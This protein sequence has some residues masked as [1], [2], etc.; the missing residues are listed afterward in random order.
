MKRPSAEIAKIAGINH[1][2]VSD[3]ELEPRFKVG[4]PVGTSGLP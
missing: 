2:I 1:D 3:I 4:V